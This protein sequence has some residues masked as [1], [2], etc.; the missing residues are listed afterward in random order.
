M[1]GPLT[2]GADRWF[3]PIGRR[4]EA[5]ALVFC[6][7]YAGGSAASYRGWGR[8]SE[9]LD[10]DVLA[11]ELPGRGRRIG[12]SPELRVSEIAAELGR[13][14]DRPY[15][16]FGHSLGARLG[17]EVCR[18][19]RDLGHAEPI[20][21]F[22]SGTPGPR[23]PRVGLGDSGLPDEELIARVNRMGGTPAEVLATPQLRELLLPLIRSDF[24]W[25]DDYVYSA[26][27]PLTCPVTALTGSAD[28]EAPPDLMR[29]W[30]RETTGEFRLCEIAGDHFFPHSA[31]ETVVTEIAADLRSQLTDDPETRARIGGER[32]RPVTGG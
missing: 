14:I 10:V 5:A 11:V 4:A 23:L 29:H 21:L 32:L 26:G 9:L 31:F 19:L 22:V 6:F 17:F 1:S 20:R 2:R 7:P 3:V 16:V 30:R 24:A 13:V 27:P 28:P 25:G 8:L 18:R 15:S 12:E